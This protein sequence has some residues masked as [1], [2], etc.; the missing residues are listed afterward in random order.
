M[1]RLYLDTGALVKLYIVEPGSESVERIVRKATSLP[2][3]VLQE[4]EL[5]NALHAAC[6]R[7]II[8]PKVLDVTLGNFEDDLNSN[9]FQREPL[10]WNFIWK[11][12]E[13]LI[14]KFTTKFLCRTLDILQVAAAE[15]CNADAIVTGDQRQIKLCRAISLKTEVI[16]YK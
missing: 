3:N 10:D 16:Q 12:S 9:I 8:T 2:I 15:S 13:Q 7:G 4:T 11:R 6:G 14:R 1:S 5:R